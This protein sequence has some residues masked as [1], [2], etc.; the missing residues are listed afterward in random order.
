MFEVLESC[1]G[2]DGPPG[3]NQ[4]R[5][6]M[7][8]TIALEHHFASTPDGQVWT[9]TAFPYRFW[10]KYLG[11]FDSVTVLARVR[12]TGKAS[13]TWDLACGPGVTFRRVP[14]YTG[15][16]QYLAKWLWI[17][18]VIQDAAEGSQA[19]ILRL[20][21]TLGTALERQFRNA[22]RPFGV[23]VVGDPY[24]VFQPGAVAHLFRPLF[25]KWFTAD[26]RRLCRKA[27]AAAYVTRF[28]L[29]QR[30]PC[31]AFSTSFSDVEIYPDGLVAAARPMRPNNDQPFRLICVGTLAQMY[32]GID[33]LV[34][35]MAISVHEGWNLTLTIV[36]EGKHRAELESLANLLGIGS[37]IRFAGQLPAGHAV[38]AELDLADLFVLPS[39][40]EGLPRAMVEAMARALPCI[41]SHI[42]GIPELL[43]A[44]CL[45]PVGDS[46]ALA[47]KLAKVLKDPARLG[48]M[49]AQNLAR[50][51]EFR[52]E[53]LSSRRV[54]FL[55][56]VRDKTAD[57]M[58]QSDTSSHA[59]LSCLGEEKSS[60]VEQNFCARS[61]AESPNPAE[62]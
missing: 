15:P 18:P 14:D 53:L 54:E 49:S 39:R 37:R 60:S 11:V 44:D 21:S 20:G 25:R 45:V 32:K 29:Q 13:G 50:A 47:S 19:V 33:V 34:R 62:L 59:Q 27:C 61:H 38:R 56:Q 57:W 55:Q 35:A 5:G 8:V 24:D 30:Y 52:E 23:E 9:E 40:Q 36:G 16:Y 1:R 43:P 4:Q 10:K 17:R 12:E 46:S 26:L 31:P 41:G 58:K 22:Q 6:F 48:R 7:N 3:G 28:A 2:V 42:G 51:K